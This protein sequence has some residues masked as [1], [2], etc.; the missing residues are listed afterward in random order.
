VALA[1]WKTT[2]ALEEHVPVKHCF[3]VAKDGVLISETNYLGKSERVEM[4]SAGKTVTALLI[5]VLVKQHSL[6]LDMTLKELNVTTE[7][8]WGTPTAA[9]PEGEYWPQVTIRHILG[10]TSG[11][12]KYTPGTEFTYDSDDYLQHLVRLIEAVTGTTSKEFATE[13]FAVP[14]GIPDLYTWDR[15]TTLEAHDITAGGGQFVTCTELLRF[16]QLILNKGRWPAK[17]VFG[18]SIQLIDEDYIEA[19]LTPQFPN[20]INNYGLLTWL[21]TKGAPPA[22]CCQ[23]QWLCN[24]IPGSKAQQGGG[25]AAPADGGRWGALRTGESIMTELEFTTGTAPINIEAGTLPRSSGSLTVR[26]M[27]L[28]CTD[29]G[30]GLSLGGLHRIAGIGMALGWLEKMLW[31]NPALNLT[32]VS[33]GYDLGGS[34]YCGEVY[35][36]GQGWLAGMD[37]VYPMSIGWVDL[38]PVLQP[39]STQQDAA[40]REIAALG[41][42][43]Q[44]AANAR[45]EN[46]NVTV[47][48]EM[49]A[50]YMAFVAAQQAERRAT[51]PRSHASGHLEPQQLLDTNFSV[52]VDTDHATKQ[53][54]P[55]AAAREAATSPLAPR[56]RNLRRLAGRRATAAS[57]DSQLNSTQPKFGEP[58]WVDSS[59]GGGSCQCYCPPTQG[60]GACKQLPPGANP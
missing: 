38:Q 44:W 6:N 36:P 41:G 18:G 54:A 34:Q 28:W 35:M 5:G 29:V 25:D 51:T 50:G 58:G 20:A 59:G 52:P 14:M 42:R 40:A 46:A 49:A 45:R 57:K 1:V 30:V 12:G 60:F 47:A 4:D 15:Y 24:V 21:S 48:E 17:D 13:H 8:D 53:H 11:I 19:M 32:V 22:N 55:D 9:D 16:G 2:R 26:P 56:G 10:Q 33:M 43:S 27:L 31:V 39:T 7:S 37:S 23:P 3:A